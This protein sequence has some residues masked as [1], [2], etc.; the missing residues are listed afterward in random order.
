LKV[1]ASFGLTGTHEAGHELQALLDRS[2]RAL[3]RAK[4]EGRD[5]IIA[6]DRAHALEAA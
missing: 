5:R 2:D 6:T 1:T 3:Y 4:N